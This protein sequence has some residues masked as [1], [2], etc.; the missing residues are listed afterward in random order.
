MIPTYF[1]VPIA[2]AGQTTG[3]SLLAAIPTCRYTAHE[4]ADPASGGA[5]PPLPGFRGR[6]EPFDLGPRASSRRTTAGIGVGD[7]RED[8]LLTYG[9][10]C[11][12]YPATAARIEVLDWPAK[13]V[14]AWIVTPGSEEVFQ[15]T[16]G[17][18]RA[19]R[20]RLLMEYA[21]APELLRA[22]LRGAPFRESP[23]TSVLGAS[24]LAVPGPTL[25]DCLPIPVFKPVEL[26]PPA[27]DDCDV[28]PRR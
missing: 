19:G 18:S 27:D 24:P 5:E 13:G 16:G 22:P 4:V 25:E 26:P 12:R 7:A 14:A 11:I 21:P 23:E 8:L 3:P 20:V 28:K 6:E 17:E 15:M 9:S 1:L 10:D 2:V